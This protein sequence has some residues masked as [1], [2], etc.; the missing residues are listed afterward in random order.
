MIDLEFLRTLKTA[1]EKIYHDFAITRSN[2]TPSTL[3]DELESANWKIRRW[4]VKEFSTPTMI[5]AEQID[6]WFSAQ[7]NSPHSSYGQL[8]STHFTSE[9][10]NKLRDT[11]QNEVAGKVVEWH[12]VS[13]FMQLSQN[14]LNAT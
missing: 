3:R 8:L 7:P 12:S 2:W 11:F 13:L 4:Q 1:E 10:L 14:N 5:T 9:Q 6:Q